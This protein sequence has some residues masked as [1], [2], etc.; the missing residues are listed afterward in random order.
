MLRL[1]FSAASF[2]WIK[3]FHYSLSQS[4]SHHVLQPYLPDNN[5]IPYQ[6]RARSHT[7]ALI[8]KTK[9]LND[10]DFVIRL[11]YKYSYWSIVNDI[12]LG[13]YYYTVSQKNCDTFIFTVTLANV[14]RFLKFFQCRNQ[15]EMAHNMNQKFPTV[16]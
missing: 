8:N 1:F 15:K 9:F 14:G 12:P 2:R 7:L 5:E 16:A 6:L 11:L 3:D 13:L 10:A 4:V